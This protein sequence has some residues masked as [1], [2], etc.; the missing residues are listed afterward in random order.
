LGVVAVSLAVM[1]PAEELQVLEVGGS[2][3]FPVLDVVCVAVLGGT[4]ASGGLAVAV[5]DDECS[6]LGGA[7]YAGRPTHVEDL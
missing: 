4:V 1:V 2:A 5:A 6:P 7:H 3:V